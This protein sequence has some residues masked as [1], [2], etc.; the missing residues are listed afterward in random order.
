MQN[1]FLQTLK[2][3]AP[4]LMLTIVPHAGYAM[5]DDE[6]VKALKHAVKV[7][8]AGVEECLACY[9]S[10][11]ALVPPSNL[12]VCADCSADRQTWLEKAGR[13]Q[14]LMAQ[15]RVQKARAMAEVEGGSSSGTGSLNVEFDPNS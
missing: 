4:L 12:Q 15:R 6:N 7:L 5:G 8:K 11:V 1:K 3:A 13:L 2:Y 9:G 10:G 14:R